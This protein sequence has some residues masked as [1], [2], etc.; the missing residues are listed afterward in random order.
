M[1]LKRIE[2]IH[3][4]REGVD[5]SMTNTVG[6]G[7]WIEILDFDKKTEK[8]DIKQ[9][10]EI[11]DIE[12]VPVNNGKKEV[13]IL[14]CKKRDIQQEL[15]KAKDL[16]ARVLSKHENILKSSL[17]RCYIDG[18]CN[19]GMPSLEYIS[20]IFKKHLEEKENEKR[21]S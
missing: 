17:I 19:S 9:R 12:F 15:S 8:V 16:A 5:P 3:E 11:T 13:M 4:Q 7:K 14:R 20:S 21:S 18:L 2:S 1:I 10:L 6:K